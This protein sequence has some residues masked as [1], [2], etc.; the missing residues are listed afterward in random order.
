MKYTFKYSA[1]DGNEARKSC[2]MAM[3]EATAIKKY[4]KAATVI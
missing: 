4:Y 1:A 3:L 2:L